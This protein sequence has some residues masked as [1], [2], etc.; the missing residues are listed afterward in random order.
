MI[1]GRGFPVFVTRT[2]PEPGLEI[3]R[4]HCDV[5]VWPQ[6]L[7]PSQADLREGIS[8]AAGVLTLVTDPVD[9]EMMDSAPDLR[10]ISN[11]AVGYDNIDVTAATERGIAVTNTPGVLTEATADFAFALLMAAARRVVEGDC[12]VRQG[13][14]LT[15]EPDFLLGKDVH[16]A[17]LGIVGLGRIGRAIASRAV[18][19]DMR[20]VYF[21]VN[22]NVEAE[23]ELGVE[24]VPFEDLLGM[25]DFISIHVPLSAETHKMLGQ[26]EL[27]SVKQGAVLVNTS[28][29]EII[30]ED[31]LVEALCEGRLG[32]AGLDV[33]SEEPLPVDHPLVQ[34]GNAVLCPHLGSASVAARKAMARI[35]AENL[36]AI[37]RGRRAE[38]VVN[39]EVLKQ[40]E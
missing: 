12:A 21:D 40:R 3:L 1:T 24:Y 6:R 13:Q 14:W 17:V 36:V 22:R 20:R 37:L 23:E 15:W 30:D 8:G 10:V 7:P 32:A 4:K 31:A 5:K 38:H 18:G 28:R 29:G 19:F 39:P 33:Y 26:A 11:Y 9:G 16:G 25:S 34:L 27:R 35:A 2:L